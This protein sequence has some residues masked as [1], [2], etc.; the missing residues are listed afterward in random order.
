MKHLDKFLLLSTTERRLLVRVSLLLIAIRVGL[1]LLPFHTLRR[2]LHIASLASIRLK[3]TNDSSAAKAIWAVNV[4]GHYMP[5]V[6]TCLTQ[7][8][9]AQALLARRGRPAT[10]YIGVVRG[11]KGQLQAH[12]WLES[13]GDIVVGRSELARYTPLVALEN[14]SQR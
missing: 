12:A 11:E 4:A 7:A 1:S 3:K 14:H 2:I 8:L 10:V 13:Q 5:G 6:G 9:T